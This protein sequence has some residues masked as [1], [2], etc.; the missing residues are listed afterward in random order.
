MHVSITK[1]KIKQ[2]PYFIDY[3]R[4]MIIAAQINYKHKKN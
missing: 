3:N 2:Y 4:K 1:N